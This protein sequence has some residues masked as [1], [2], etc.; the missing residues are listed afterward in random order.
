MPPELVLAERSGRVLA[1]TLNRPQKL[2]ALSKGLL[3]DLSH[4]LAQAAGDDGVGCVILTGAGRA[5][6]A[7]ADIA[8]ML[9]RGVASYTDARR[10]ESWRA[11]EDFPKPLIAAVNGFAFGGGLELALLCD[12][13]LAADTAQFA[14]PET[15]IGSF[16]GDG[17]TQRLPHFVGRSFAMQ[18]ILTGAV[19]GASLAERKGLVSEIHAPALLLPRARALAEEIA[20]ASMP[21]LM[22][23]KRAVRAA[24]ENHLAEGL[25]IEHRLTVESFATEDRIEGLKAFVEKRPPKFSHR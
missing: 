16:P 22:L 1:L 9:A 14:C 12:I 6:S 4:H 2:N 17:G 7:G 19:I 13:I 20:T 24:A 11:I 21:A 3:V 18:M 5:F 25:R 10:L 15:K 8:D 23:A